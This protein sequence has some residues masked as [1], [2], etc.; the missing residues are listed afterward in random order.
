MGEIGEGKPPQ[1]QAPTPPTF[2]VDTIESL[3][4]P[5]KAEL[6]AEGAHGRVIQFPRP[7][8]SGD[9]VLR[10][11]DIP[12]PTSDSA[13]S[14]KK[15]STEIP[16]I[17]RKPLQRGDIMP[18]NE[19]VVLI[20]EDGKE[21]GILDRRRSDLVLEEIIRDGKKPP[22]FVLR[23]PDGKIIRTSKRGPIWLGHTRK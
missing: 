8:A 21:V 1:K 14:S 23:T 13:S 11:Q 22:I 16:R 6:E 7:T 5:S 18:L 19:G 15:S 17:K 9:L 20:D 2:G 12:S 4:P 10:I 3:K